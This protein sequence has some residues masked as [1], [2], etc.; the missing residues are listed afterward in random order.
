MQNTVYTATNVDDIEA[1]IMANSKV[2]KETY[3]HSFTLPADIRKEVRRELDLMGINEM[4]MFPDMD[5]LCREM[6]RR[7]FPV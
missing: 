5:G 7:H 6:K 3:L 4:T 1:H 2:K